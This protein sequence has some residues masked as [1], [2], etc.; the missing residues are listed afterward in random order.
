MILA[1][2]ICALF[3]QE[4]TLF[5]ILDAIVLRRQNRNPLSYLDGRFNFRTFFSI[6]IRTIRFNAN[7][8]CVRA[9]HSPRAT[10][11]ATLFAVR[12]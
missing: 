6:P 12:T 8:I 2:S 3:A 10:E 11:S 4:T 7:G 9:A 5:A 1:D